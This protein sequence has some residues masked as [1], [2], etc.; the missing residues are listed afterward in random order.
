MSNRMAC[1]SRP[2]LSQLNQQA[3]K[4]N[5]RQ[6]DHCP[7]QAVELA[8]NSLGVNLSFFAVKLLLCFANLADRLAHFLA[9]LSAGAR[10][11]NPPGNPRRSKTSSRQWKQFQ[12]DPFFMGTDFRLFSRLTAGRWNLSGGHRFSGTVTGEY[13]L[14]EHALVIR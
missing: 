5:L 10:G 8:L 12:M 3:P 1:R 9:P 6:P 7:A 13:C 11:I 4:N 14:R 2:L